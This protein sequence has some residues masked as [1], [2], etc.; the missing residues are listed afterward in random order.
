V[1][2]I[3]H[4][5]CPVD[6]S[7]VS[8]SAL[9]HAFAWADWFGAELHVIHVAPMPIAVPGMPGVVVTLDHDSRART[10]RELREFAQ[11]VR[12]EGVPY[13]AR[14]V[15]GDPAAVIV[16]EAKG[17]RNVLLILGSRAMSGIE[18]IVLG[19]VAERVMHRTKVPTLVLP[20]ASELAFSAVSGFKRI[21]CGVNLH[22]SS[23]EALR[24]AVSLA[25]EWDAHL[26]IV[27]VL[28][29]L[30]AVL[31]I[32]TPAH[33]IAEHRQEQQQQA[34]RAIRQHVPEDARLA[35]TVKEEIHV[36]EAVGTLLDVVHQDQAELL[37][38]GAGDWPHLSALWRG[39]TTD[40]LV[41]QAK[42]PVLVVPTPPA[43]R[44]AA[45]MTAA[46]IARVQWPTILD[47]INTE[48]RGHF[49]TVTVIDREMSALPEV[50]ALPLTG[51]VLDRGEGGAIELILGDR[52]HSHLTHVIE[53]PT[54][55]RVERVW[56]TSARL[57]VS[58]A[59]GTATL[60]EIAAAPHTALE[61]LATSTPPF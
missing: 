2:Q 35:C 32:G 48:L 38:V 57:L 6:F 10:E 40:R 37:V 45:A 58:D 33:V 5:L 11:A 42:C 27:S 13:D 15:Q 36:G 8:R 47:R 34:L 3:D 22:L 61:A 50:T 59:S 19:S 31:P 28:D 53:R 9:A 56:M 41:R 51:I 46:P 23:V 44:R 14:V 43:V 24:Y 39:H 30:A 26:R 7:A 55:L 12:R 17:Y 21:V 54:E 16:D 52:E 25:T 60:V 4:I 29:P 49:T 1:R 18:R 20:A